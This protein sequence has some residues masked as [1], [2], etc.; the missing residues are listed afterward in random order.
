MR[1]ALLS[2]GPRRLKRLIWNKEFATT[3]W[4]FIDHT[5]GDCVYPPLERHAKNGAILDLGC[6]PGNTANELNETSYISYLGVDISDEALAKAA[7]RTKESGRREKNR[8]VTGDFLTYEPPGKFDVILFRE[9]MYHVPIAKIR[10][11]LNR[12]ARNLT[13]RGVFI[14]RMHLTC[15]NGEPV[16]RPTKMVEVIEGAFD[17]VERV[18]DRKTGSGVIVF[19]PNACNAAEAC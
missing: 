14:V 5:V 13:E 9:S 6:G 8:F 15:E 3:K 11:L 1:G 17:V 18:H 2:Y 10:P 19:R 4:N 7:L 16:R 12:Y